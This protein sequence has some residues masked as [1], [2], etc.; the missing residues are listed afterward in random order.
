MRSQSMRS[1][2]ILMVAWLAGC[3]AAELPKPYVASEP[4][5]GKELKF[6]LEP[7]TGLDAETADLHLAVHA[8]EEADDAVTR[9]HREVA[10]FLGKRNVGGRRQPNEHD[11][12]EG[13]GN[14]STHGGNPAKGHKRRKRK[15]SR[16][17]FFA[18][19]AA[20]CGQ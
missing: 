17:I 18:R 4:V 14:E 1:L 16:L 20:F 15:N 8:P 9:I 3:A 12:R 13:E 6:Y 7:S 19:P 5:D 10:G 2:M 11:E